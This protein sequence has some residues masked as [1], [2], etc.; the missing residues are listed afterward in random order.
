MV[1]HQVTACTVQ[2][3]ADHHDE[4]THPRLRYPKSIYAT[5]RKP[6]KPDKSGHYPAILE[7]TLMP[8]PISTRKTLNLQWIDIESTLC[9]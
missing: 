8:N 2:D 9:S 5:T 6:S 1:R 4:P 3:E 7:A